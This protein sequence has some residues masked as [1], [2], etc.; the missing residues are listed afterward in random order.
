MAKHYDKAFKEDA[1]QYHKD[2]PHLTVAAVCRNLGISQPTF[3]IWKRAAEANDGEVQ[4]RG[5]G[6]YESDK[7]K[8]NARLRKELKDTQ[9]ALKVL[10]KA[11][12]ILAQDEQK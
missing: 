7:A 1:L 6:N 8:E 2:N 5:S 3:Y 9:D 4:H 10:K 12:G 11:M